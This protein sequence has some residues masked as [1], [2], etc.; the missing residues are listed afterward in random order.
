MVMRPPP[1][2]TDKKCEKCGKPMLLRVGK[3]GPFL[4]C[5]GFPALPQ[6]Q[7]STRRPRPNRRTSQRPS[8]GV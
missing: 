2:M 7:K 4:T 6:P 3:R 5:S 1:Q 8:D